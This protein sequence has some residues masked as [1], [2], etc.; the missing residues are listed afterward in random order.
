VKKILTSEE[1]RSEAENLLL[2]TQTSLI[3]FSGFIK[4][5]AVAWLKDHVKDSVEVSII[6]RFSASDLIGGASDLDIYSTC[7][8]QGW[9]AG[10]LNNLHSKVFIF[11]NE[12]LML[13]SANLTMRGLSLEGFGNIELGTKLVPTDDDQKRI[14]DMQKDIIWIDDELYEAMQSEINS[15]DKEEN[16]KDLFNWS[17][18]LCKR[19]K[20][21]D[22]NLWVKDLLHSSPKDF[23]DQIFRD[24]N[25]SV[26]Q[27]DERVIDLITKSIIDLGGEAKLEEI[28]NQVNKYREVPSP[29]IRARIYE[30][31]SECDAYKENNPD[32]FISSDGKG[33]GKWRIRKDVRLDLNHDVLKDLYLLNNNQKEIKIFENKI[34]S[35]E[36]IA[37]LF[38]QTKVFNWLLNLLRENEDHTHK[39]FGWVTS[40]LHSA[41]MDD[42]A[43][44]RGGIKFF[45][46][47]LFKW[48]EAFGRQE[49]QI[50]HY[51]VTTGLDLVKS[52]PSNLES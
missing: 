42:P 3:I 48:I 45:V 40:H 17:N 47:N 22:P 14:D 16:S 35:Q 31:S 25:R 1:F 50:T 46:N 12:Y 4:S 52:D 13:G 27:K 6:G 19:L 9:K 43:P 23:N 39:N 20:P 24:I 7:K 36:D 49:I 38:I 32:L 28:Y 30:H 44:S 29:S 18:D 51:D 10:I 37:K 8:E 34:E 33:D 21:A 2:T 15:F 5:S 41:L 11:D 26:N